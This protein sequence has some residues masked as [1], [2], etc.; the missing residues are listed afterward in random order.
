MFV[1]IFM[2][3]YTLR[4]TLGIKKFTLGINSVKL[5]INSA[6]QGINS[7]KLGINSAILGITSATQYRHWLVYSR[8]QLSYINSVPPNNE[9]QTIKTIILSQSRV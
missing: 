7:V 5:D 2:A 4:V 8:H 1:L 6:T 3:F 9:T